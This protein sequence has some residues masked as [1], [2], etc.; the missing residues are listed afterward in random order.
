MLAHSAV[1]SAIIGPR[2]MEQLDGILAAG[3][4]TLDDDVLDRIDELVPPGTDVSTA[5]G[6]WIAAVDRAVL[7]APAPARGPLIASCQSRI[8][9]IGPIPTDRTGH[10][11]QAAVSGASTYHWWSVNG[12]CSASVPSAAA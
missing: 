12:L 4:P 3:A 8:G 6:G 2:T 10:H 5:D 9:P 7:A 11:G 1:S